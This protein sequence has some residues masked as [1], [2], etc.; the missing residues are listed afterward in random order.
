M[1]QICSSTFDSALDVMVRQRLNCRNQTEKNQSLL[2]APRHETKQAVSRHT[3]DG[4]CSF[5][6]CCS[7]GL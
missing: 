1:S 4:G 2:G 5:T 3:G 7:S 6:L